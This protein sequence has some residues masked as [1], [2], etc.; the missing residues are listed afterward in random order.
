MRAVPM[1]E[2][3]RT[4]P[5]GLVLTA[6]EPVSVMAR[7]LTETARLTDVAAVLERLPG[8]PGSP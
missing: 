6:R 1:V 8:D 5:V 7:A 2:P 4:V 3:D